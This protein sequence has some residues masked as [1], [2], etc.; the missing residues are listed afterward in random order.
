MNASQDK[1]LSTSPKSGFHDLKVVFHKRANPVGVQQ[2][3]K[4]EEING[5]QFDVRKARPSE[6]T[7]GTTGYLERSNIS[8]SFKS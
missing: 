8:Q 1:T 4:Q 5:L 2:L 6:V 3:G 7:K